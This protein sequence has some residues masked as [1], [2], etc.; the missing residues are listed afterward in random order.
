[1]WKGVIMKFASF[2][3]VLALLFAP[4]AASANEIKIPEDECAAYFIADMNGTILAERN[5]DAP[6]KIASITKVMTYLLVKEAIACG[7][8]TLDTEFPIS[9]HAAST[10]GSSAY[11]TA[12][13]KLTVSDLLDAMMIISANDAASALAEGLCGSED[14]FA[15]KMEEKAREL[16]FS[17]IHFVNASG[18]PMDET[19]DENEATTKDLWRLAREVITR[20]PEILE[21]RNRRS[22]IHNNLEI[23]STM[24][25][26]GVY[27]GVDGLK[28]GYTE[29]AGCC[30]LTSVNM[31]EASGRNE[32]DYRLIVV[33]MGTKNEAA[34][35]ERTVELIDWARDHYEKKLLIDPKESILHEKD[36]KTIPAHPQSGAS[37]LLK[38]G[39]PTETKDTF[40]ITFPVEKGM[41]IGTRT[42]RTKDV[43]LANVPI[44]ADEDVTNYTGW[45]AIKVRI[46]Y[47]FNTVEELFKLSGAK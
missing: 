21:Y 47:F 24:K 38:K 36:G 19:E 39:M 46:Q 3:L 8:I 9:E 25:L 2:F 37:A 15:K 4:V 31:K 29:F 32:D 41:V 33:V 40:E 45:E 35:T 28:T 43:I 42:V 34:R 6:R 12:G 5:A 22:F 27:P 11:L 23:G 7:K 44:L 18:L 30:L 17:H 10:F 20:H 26:Y 14:A 16:G 1:M 13:E